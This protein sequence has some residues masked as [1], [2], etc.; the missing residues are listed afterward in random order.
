MYINWSATTEK[1]IVFVPELYNEKTSQKIRTVCC[2]NNKQIAILISKQRKT[3]ANQLW[4]WLKDYPSVFWKRSLLLYAVCNVWHFESL[5][6]VETRSGSKGSDGFT[7]KPNR[8]WPTTP[9]FQEPRA[10]PSYDDSLL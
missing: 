7:H 10:T 9:R 1:L 3:A 5:Q 2:T 8:L 4:T 6:T